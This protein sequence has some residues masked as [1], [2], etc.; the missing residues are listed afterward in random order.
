MEK[1]VFEVK[2]N[3]LTLWS[4]YHYLTQLCQ[5]HQI[6]HLHMQNSLQNQNNVRKTVACEKDA[7]MG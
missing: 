7:Q 3:I 6:A 4:Q 1:K 5:G 2:E